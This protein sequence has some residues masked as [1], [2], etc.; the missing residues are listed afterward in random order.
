M[1]VRVLPIMA[2]GLLLLGCDSGGGGGGGLPQADGSLHPNCSNDYYQQLIGTYRGV[3][4]RASVEDDGSVVTDCEWDTEVIVRPRS[5]ASRCALVADV[6]A[7]VTQLVI[8]PADDRNAFQCFGDESVARRLNDPNDDLETVEAFSRV[9]FPIQID[10][11][12]D[13]LAPGF[14]PYFGDESVD[15]FYVWL[16]DGTASVFDLWEF[17]SDDTLTFVDTSPV[18]T[19]RETAVLQKVTP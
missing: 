16:L 5:A 6:S 14:G 8:L 13:P 17:G 11:E 15:A 19:T 12:V 18:A 1:N 7:E 3:I 4:S 10:V 2:V 9:S